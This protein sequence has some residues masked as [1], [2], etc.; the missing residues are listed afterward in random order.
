LDAHQGLLQRSD[1]AR[2]QDNHVRQENAFNESITDA[3]QTLAIPKTAG[4]YTQT[5]EPRSEQLFSNILPVARYGQRIFTANTTFREPAALIKSLQQRVERPRG[6][7]FLKNEKLF[8]FYDLKSAPW[9]EVC[10]AGTVD[11]FPSDDW[12]LSRDLEKTN[13]F[14]RLLRRCL[15]DHLGRRGVKFFRRKKGVL[16]YYFFKATKDLKPRVERWK[17]LQ[18]WASRTVFEAYYGKLDPTRIV[19]YRHL[20]FHPRFRRFAGQWYLEITPTYHFTKDGTAADRYREER[21]SKI[22]RIEKNAAV[23]ANV[24]FWGRFINPS[25]DLFRKGNEFIQLGDLR[26]FDVDFGLN[27]EL[28]RNKAE[29]DEKAELEE[30]GGDKLLLAL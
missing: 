28:W 13:D 8:S 5:P 27:D 10:D 20:A 7:W 9:N 14:V 6:E 1:S 19:Y 30:E 23:V 4:I 25:D 16:G 3:L 26:D 22:K 17:A 21:L 24:L 18:K 2:K 11:D 12:A 29:D 15:D